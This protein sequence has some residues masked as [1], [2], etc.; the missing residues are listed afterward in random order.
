MVQDQYGQDNNIN[1]T[2]AENSLNIFTGFY[3]IFVH[4][5]SIK[6]VKDSW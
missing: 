6:Y 4:V 2:V 1:L 3:H 5:K